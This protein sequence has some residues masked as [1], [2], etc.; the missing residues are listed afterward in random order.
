MGTSAVEDLLAEIRGGPVGE[1]IAAIFDLDG[2]LIDGY[3]AGAIYSHRLTHGQL[4]PFE[5]IRTLRRMSGPTLTEEQFEEL[6]VDGIRGWAGRPVEEILALGEKLFSGGPGGTVGNLFHEAWRLVRAHQNAGHTV[7]IATSATEMQV[8]PLARELGIEHVLCTRLEERDGVLTGGI[9][10]R[11]L[12]GP[13]KLA[14]IEAFM[15]ERGLDLTEAHG[16]ANGD[17]DVP[18]LGAVEHP[19]PVNPQ[20]ELL[21]AAQRYGWPVLRLS[22]GKAGR[23]DPRPAL[24]TATL[25]GTLLGSAGAGIALG[26]L[27]R[28]RRLG[29]DVTTSLFD[30]LAGPLTD[31]HVEVA[32][33]E[34]AWSARPA[35]FVLNHQSTMIDF[36]VTTRVVRTGWTAVAKA[37]AKQMPVVGQLFDMAGVCFLDRSDRERAI[38]GLKPAVETLRSGTSIVI[39]PEGTRSL[40]PKLGRFK[41]GAFHLA[42]QAEVPIVPIVV[43][44]AGE[45]MWRNARTARAG[46][47]QVVVLPPI[48]TTG[49]T[50]DDIDA[51]ALGLQRTYEEMLDNWPVADN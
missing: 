8:V 17:E 35:V 25:F 15:A 28:N 12:W 30:T 27:N 39:A 11:T 26:V 46:T 5:L 40:T 13:G 19:H 41:K 16:Y 20:P 42:A 36:L 48:Q 51:N 44:N 47:I 9:E 2:T 3:T 10:G 24:R 7:V 18:M 22:S 32:G 45:I 23:L 31:I 1:K 37:E 34:H 14:A 43:R 21:E 38:E 33:E 6:L 49:W 50:K 4:G 29:V